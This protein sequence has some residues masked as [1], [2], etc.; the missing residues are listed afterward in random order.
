MPAHLAGRAERALVL[1]E[2]VDLQWSGGDA[3]LV[4]RASDAA[5]RLDGVAAAIVDGLSVPTTLGALCER[6][7]REFDVGEDECATSVATFVE[8]L[9]E[10]GRA[11]VLEAPAGVTKVRRRYL[12]LLARALVNLIY[13]EHELRVDHLEREGARPT[14]IAQRRLMRDIRYA[15]AE[16]F[17]ELIEAKRDG[18]PWRGRPSPDAHTMIG[19]RRLENLE[20]CAVRVF[21][22]EVPGDF[23]E[24]GVCRGGASVFLRALQVAYDEEARVTWVADSFAGLPE[25]SHPVDVAAGLDFSEPRQPWLAASLPAVR[26][27]FATYDLLSDGV[28]FLP[29]WF[30]ESLPDAAVERLALLRIDADLHSSTSEALTALYDRVSPGG[31]V[32]VDDYNSV[33]ACRVAVDGFLAARGIRA[34]IRPIDRNAVF[35]RKT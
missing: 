16:Q 5:F 28:R 3:V 8:G 1:G 35:W 23:L 10:Q 22:D 12:D 34:E 17:T 18:L 20:R 29:G 25:P 27:T 26:E 14:A 7:R 13:P 33:E 32:V 9:R 19:L 21:A 6:V 4:D 31:Y 11:D 2:Q 30:A 15:H 24:A